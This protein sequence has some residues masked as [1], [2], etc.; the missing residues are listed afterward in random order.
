MKDT[1]TPKD[2]GTLNKYMPSPTIFKKIFIESLP[3][4]GMVALIPFIKNDYTLT[5]IYILIIVVMLSI[6]QEKGDVFVCIF[7]FVAMIFFETIF[8]TTGVETFIRNSLFGIM[9]LWLPFLWGYGFIAI[10]RGVQILLR[11]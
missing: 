4:I 3:V 1:T 10:R 2:N 9:P 8:I 6:K 7:G 5:G 11:N